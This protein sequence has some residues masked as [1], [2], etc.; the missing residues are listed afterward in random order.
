MP[1][2][3]VHDLVTSLIVE[4]YTDRVMS[5]TIGTNEH[6]FAEARISL[7]LALA[8]AFRLYDRPGALHGALSLG[9]V[10]GGLAYEG[11][12]EDLAIKPGGAELGLFG[13]QRALGDVPYTAL[14]SNTRVANWRIVTS[15][16]LAGITK[17]K[18]SFD[19]Q[20]RLFIGLQKNTLYT[21]NVD[22]LAWCY[23]RPSASTRSFIGIQFDFE[24]LLP[25]GFQFGINT[26]ND[27]FG[28]ATGVL[29]IAATGALQKGAINITFAAAGIALLYIYNGSGG[30]IT[31]AGENGT[32][33][34]KVTNVRL[35][36]S[37]TNRINT[38]L[39]ANRAA[40]TN[41]T[42]TVGSTA[43]M[44]VGQQLQIK[45]GTVN[46]S[47]TV[48]VLS[49]GS[50]TQFNATFANAYVIGDAVQ[51]HVIYADEIVKDMVSATNAVNSTQLSG[52]TALIQS[53]TLDLLNEVYEDR[54]PNDILDY[55]IGLGDSQ[56]TPR[57]WE[58]GVYAGRVLYFQPR[59]ATARTWYVDIAAPEVERTIEALINSGYAT[60]KEPGGRTLRT[61]ASTDS[62]STNRWGITR[63]AAIKTDTTSS[64][65]AGVRRDAQ[66]AD[67]K[68]PIPRAAIA[69]DA[70]YDA[71]GS[72]W[73]LTAVHAGDTCFIRNLPATVNSMIIERIRIFRTKR[74]TL[75]L[76]AGKLSLEP[77]S[78]LPT[79]IA[80][81]ATMIG[82]A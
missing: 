42:A 25:A 59:G 68:D 22:T 46:G 55:L 81:A 9:S 66:I 61:A 38:T 75:D 19:S 64:T 7:R 73:P 20:N 78:P 8:E 71:A 33:Y 15:D 56:A 48:T 60:Y 13:Y 74:T 18:G 51:G 1:Q 62:I 45:Q 11:R 34:L 31:F 41:V 17:D 3:G 24:A 26:Y 79:V 53:P 44:Y 70:I 57:Q 14:W 21:N 28:G 50:S 77:E 43:G 58:W 52:T 76:L 16:D 30:N 32:N 82:G 63:R 6:G 35:V 4:D 23:Q 72:R 5:A 47:E 27:T 2:F 37:T 67:K 69:V 65:E 39:T 12:L 49:I 40:G 10:L 80:P 36:T 54:Y 29:N